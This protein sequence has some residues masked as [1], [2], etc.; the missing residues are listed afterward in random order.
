MFCTQTFF[1]RTMICP[2]FFERR[3]KLW[4][5]CGFTLFFADDL[6]L[7][8]GICKQ[9]MVRLLRTVQSFCTSLHMKLSVEKTVMLSSGLDDSSWNFLSDDPTLEISLMGRY[10]GF[11]VNVKGRNLITSCEKKLISTDRNYAHTIFGCTKLGLDRSV[12]ANRVW[13]CCTIPS[14]LYALE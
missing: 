5:Y 8:S 10:L 9:G 2:K 13:E 4:Q 6:V 7:I 1:L 11:E 3:D 14:I 12:T